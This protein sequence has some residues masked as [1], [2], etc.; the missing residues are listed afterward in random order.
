MVNKRIKS[1]RKKTVI[2]AVIA[3]LVIL[4]I[5]WGT[6]SKLEV[7]YYTVESSLIK[8]NIKALLISDLH[9][10]YYGKEQEKLIKEIGKINPDVIFMAGDIYDEDTDFSG[11][12]ILLEAI[13]DKYQCFFVTGNHEFWTYRAD[14][15]KE[16][17]RGY[18]ITVLEGDTEVI[19][20]KGQSI[21]VSGVDDLD[22]GED[23]FQEQLE[24]CGS[25]VGKGQFSIL[26]THRP[27]L[28]DM[29]NM[30]DFNLI[31]CGHAHGGQ[32]RIPFILKGLYSPNQ[33]WFPVFTSGK[34]SFGNSAMIVSRGLSKKLMPRVFNK[35]E[36]I[37]I[38]IN[39]V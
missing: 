3:A 33:G 22:I 10:S 25:Q 5:I 19:T 4:L 38:N 11:S 17:V 31:L 21:A 8:T 16:K 2:T 14:E 20:V 37:V 32:V 7:N 12:D 24:K 6:S 39:I 13:G 28:I 1:I 34:Y 18:N 27:E 36:L 23:I 15:I 30:N 29:Y 26:L 35:P 9:G